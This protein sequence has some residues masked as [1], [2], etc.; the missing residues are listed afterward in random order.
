MYPNDRPGFGIDVDEE[1][2]SRYPCQDEIIDWTQARL[3]D[4][5]P[6][7]PEVIAS[8]NSKSMQGG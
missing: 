3:P 4:A 6:R 7:G 5:H 1:L 2:A 8:R